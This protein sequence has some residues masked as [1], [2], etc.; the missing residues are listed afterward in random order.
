MRFTLCQNVQ[1]SCP[2]VPRGTQHDVLHAISARCVARDLHT[3]ALGPLEGRCW[4]QFVAQWG[5]S[6]ISICAFQC[7]YYY[8]CCCSCCCRRLRH[9]HHHHHHHRTC[10]LSQSRYSDTGPAS[11]S[12]DPNKPGARQGSHWSTNFQVIDMIL[13]GK[14]PWGEWDSNPGMLATLEADATEAASHRQG[15]AISRH[16]CVGL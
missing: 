6:K 5:V 1:L 10:I 7:T 12:S 11:P 14:A 3:T 16:A 15:H 13:S 9:H 2:Y 4:R 8:H